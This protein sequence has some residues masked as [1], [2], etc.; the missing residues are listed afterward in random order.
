M[1][2]PNRRPDRG[3]SDTGGVLS[4]R[5]FGEREGT[6]RLDESRLCRSSISG[7][8]GFEPGSG[9]D[10]CRAPRGA[11]TGTRRDQTKM[12]NGKI[13]ITVFGRLPR[14]RR[15]RAAGVPAIRSDDPFCPATNMTAERP[16]S[17][18]RLFS[19]APGTRTLPIWVA[20]AVAA[21]FIQAL[22]VRASGPKGHRK[23][24]TSVAVGP[25]YDTTHIYVAPTD[26]DAFVTSF[27][28]TFGGNP[29]K[30][31]LVNVLPVPS[32]TELQAVLSPVG[33]LSIFAFQTPVPFPFGE[34]RTGYLVTDMDRAI[35]AAR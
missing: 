22:P 35:K 10:P 11:V 5:R 4:V 21:A 32:S 34:E 12:K 27:V 19:I 6:E 30:R 24:R 20:I 1:A 13:R 29:T 7:Y 31:S 18:V 17:V 25:Q 16:E 9:S 26:L 23:H 14:R 33:V 8:R 15:A 2:S 3:D 28:W